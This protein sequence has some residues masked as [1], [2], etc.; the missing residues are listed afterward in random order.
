M[1]LIAGFA[2]VLMFV[3]Q[4]GSAAAR[5]IAAVLSSDQPRYREAHRAFVK[6]LE[7]RGYGSGK[8]EII[9]QSP[10]PDPLSWANVI[11]KFN[12]YRPDLIIAYGAGASSVALKESD[13]ISV[14]SADLYAL[15]K[16][17]KSVC[18]VSSRV[19]MMTLIKT[20]QAIHP[21]RNIGI[22]YTSR[23]AGSL[24]QAEDLRKAA[25]QFGAKTLEI[26][27][28]SESTLDHALTSML[29]K[30]D[31]VVVTESSIACRY[32]ERIISRTTPRAI[33]VVST[34]P[35][36]AE[37]GA[38]LSLEINPQEQGQLAA[39]IAV[40]IMEGA[41][42][43]NLSLLTPRRVDLVVNMRVANSMKITLPF[44]TLGSV[45]RVI[46]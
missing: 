26:N 41:N 21:Y 5:V 29:A 27:V 44:Q 43:A 3:P 31:M 11:R 14:V 46:K 8:V 45:T 9:L 10:N 6:S 38:L 32:F 7:A 1:L 42:P 23:E 37:K 35:D 19:P 18:G 33:P 4:Y 34:M 30:V 12:A 25:S 20:M 13:N 15:E 2:F 40:R 16:D 17:L 39:E 24:R 22:L 28:T 36:A